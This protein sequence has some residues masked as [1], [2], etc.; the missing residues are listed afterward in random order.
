[1]YDIFAELI[2]DANL[3]SECRCA[4]IFRFCFSGS[5][6]T[7]KFSTK[8]KLIGSDIW[9]LKPSKNFKILSKWSYLNH[10][11]SQIKLLFSQ[12]KMTSKR[13]MFE[14]VFKKRTFKLPNIEVE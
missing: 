9:F 2:D 12:K 11:Q 4:N 8:I 6:V 7:F 13:S 1:M 10:R 14:I 3:V 5:I